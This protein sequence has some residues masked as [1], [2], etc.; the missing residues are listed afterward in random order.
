[1]LLFQNRISNGDLFSIPSIGPSF[2]E[3]SLYIRIETKHENNYLT[4]IQEGV[5]YS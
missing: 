2:Q 1:M 3:P 5:A 4:V